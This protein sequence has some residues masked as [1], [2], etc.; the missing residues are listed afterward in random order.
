MQFDIFEVLNS[1]CNFPNSVPFIRESMSGVCIV[2]VVVIAALSVS[3][4]TRY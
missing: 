2:V 1:G 3:P 4:I